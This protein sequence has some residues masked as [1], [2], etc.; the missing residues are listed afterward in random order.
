MQYSATAAALQIVLLYLQNNLPHILFI[1]CLC[2]RAYYN[3]QAYLLS[4]Q[5]YFL[6]IC[7]SRSGS[8]FVSLSLSIKETLLFIMSFI[9]FVLIFKVYIPQSTYSLQDMKKQS[10][11]M[12]ACTTCTAF[13]FVNLYPAWW[14]L[15]CYQERAKSSHTKCQL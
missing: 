4:F 12:V 6:V 14:C 2:V 10:F 3:Y 13:S 11:L 5:P 1:E 9:I 7:S 8:L 15:F